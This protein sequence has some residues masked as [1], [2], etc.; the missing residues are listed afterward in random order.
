LAIFVALYSNKRNQLNIFLNNF[1]SDHFYLGQSVCVQCDET[2]VLKKTLQ[3]GASWW[4]RNEKVISILMQQNTQGKG[5]RR[6]GEGE[7]LPLSHV[8][9]VLCHI[10]KIQMQRQ[11]AAPAIR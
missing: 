10:C 4:M 8:L 1:N 11:F 9:R 5:K 2:L 6:R 3:N 7:S